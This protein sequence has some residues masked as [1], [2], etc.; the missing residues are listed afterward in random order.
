[1]P[2]FQT[3][4]NPFDD[5]RNMFDNAAQKTCEAFENSKEYVERAK[6]RSELNEKYRQLGKAEFEYAVGET[7]DTDAI[8][9]LV[10]EIRELRNAYVDICKLLRRGEAPICPRCAKQNVLGNSYC[11]D[12]GARLYTD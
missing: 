12:C 4:G 3:S 10:A 9:T 11:S 1:M 2:M 8:D 7:D 6:L 5:L